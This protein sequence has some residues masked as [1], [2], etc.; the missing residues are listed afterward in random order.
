MTTD[1]GKAKRGGRQAEDSSATSSE[2]T[3]PVE[4]PRRFDPRCAGTSAR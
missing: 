2:T 1:Q 3:L 4:G